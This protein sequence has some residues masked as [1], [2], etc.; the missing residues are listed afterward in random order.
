MKVEVRKF[1]PA[2]AKDFF[3]LHST[4]PGEC[5]C[6]FWYLK[7][8][9]DWS[10]KTAEENRARREELLKAGEYDGYLAYMGGK[11]AGWC[12]VGPRDRLPHL[13]RRM[14]LRPDAA[15]HAISCFYILPGERRQ[16]VAAAMLAHVLAELRKKGVRRVEAFPRRG[17]KLTED[18]M[19]NGPEEMLAHAGFKV[20]R[21]D[22]Q[23]PVMSLDL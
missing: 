18:D 13:R 15:V 20:V 23:R 22:A 10:K 7:E 9:E 16:G 21:E 3:A 1:A 19:W 12:Q 14:V 2:L 11:V 8:N 4:P 5:F 6:A 17:E